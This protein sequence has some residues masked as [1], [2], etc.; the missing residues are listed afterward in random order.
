MEWSF[1][2]GE[3]MRVKKYEIARAID[4]I[5]S[6]VQKN[7]QIKALA[8]ILV[9]DGYLTGSNAEITVQVKLEGSAGE[10]F[11]I[12]MAAFDLIRN[13]PEGDVDITADE[14]NVVTI[15][16]A[17]ITNR[18]QSFPP[19]AFS[20]YK[21]DTELGEELILPG[22]ELM[23]ALGHVVFA[24][25]DKDV[26]ATM[27]GIYFDGGENCLNVVGLDG[28]VIAWDKVS[29]Q[30][31]SEMKAIVPKTAVK[32]LLSMGMTDDV[33]VS[34]DKQ[35]IIF[36]TDEYKI[37]SRLIDGKYFAYQ[38]MFQDS[39]IFTVVAKKDLVDAM[40]RAKMCTTEGRAAIF[41]LLGSE[42]NVS[43]TDTAADYN[44]TV[45]LEVD[46]SPQ[47]VRIGFNSK[48]V[49]DTIKAFT[50]ENITLNFSTSV[51]PM[52]VG[53]EDSDMRALVLPV[54]LKD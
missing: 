44:E 30:G 10:A 27:N 5:K 12:P 11:I 9:K 14:N 20:F 37:S 46:I 42:M 53:A 6:V 2:K 13:L 22:E 26:N 23:E 28:H 34:H 54:K 33:R 43:I 36:R 40:T 24:A 35:S 19:D 32:K 45:P 15:K 39:P 47:D 31:V 50:C 41:R 1:G 48:L 52:Y 38:R 51:Q 17:R 7:E 8:G 21:P 29:A 49:L 4:K 25:A 3:W 18:Y 16:M